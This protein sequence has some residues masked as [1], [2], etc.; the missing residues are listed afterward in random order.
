MVA[1]KVTDCIHSVLDPTG[2]ILSNVGDTIGCL[3]GII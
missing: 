3:P 1:P 2:N